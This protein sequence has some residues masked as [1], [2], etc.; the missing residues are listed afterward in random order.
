MYRR[1][2]RPIRRYTDY[3]FDKIDR[4]TYII[5]IVFFIDTGNPIGDANKKYTTEII[6]KSKKKFEE[7]ERRI[8]RKIVDTRKRL[9]KACIGI[10]ATP[11]NVALIVREK[12]R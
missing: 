8:H 10:G 12:M 3:S 4:S 6:C 1:L 2:S 7:T 11:K 5:Q 9:E